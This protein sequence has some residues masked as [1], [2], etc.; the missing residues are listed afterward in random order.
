MRRFVVCLWIGW[1]IWGCDRDPVQAARRALAK[2]PSRAIQVLEQATQQQ[3]DCFECLA[4]LGA[5]RE[6]QKDWAGA[7]EAYRK[8]MATPAAKTRTEPVAGRLWLV[9]EALFQGSSDPATRTALAREAA[10]LE[11][12]MKVARPWGNQ[13]LLEEARNEMASLAKEGREADLRRTLEQAMALY[14]PADAKKA[15]AEQ[16]TGWLRDTFVARARAAFQA[17]GLQERLSKDRTFDPEADEVVL[18]HRF[19][20]PSAREDPRFNPG[21]PDFWGTVRQEACLP[22]RQDLESLV[23]AIQQPLGL[24]EPTPADL[25]WIFAEAFQKARGGFARHGAPDRNPAG[26][27]WLCEVR[28]PLEAFLQQVFRISE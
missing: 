11:S 21:A 16:G 9:L 19:R 2:D 27:E 23:R 5:I 18:A 7:A 24:R 13:F 15:L 8:A 14:L 6:Q 1:A 20:I 4:W 25:D 3:P 28:M 12:E 10:A 17:G 22:L 26:E